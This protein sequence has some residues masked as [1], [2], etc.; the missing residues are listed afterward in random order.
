MVEKR[1]L[2]LRAEGRDTSEDQ[3][4]YEIPGTA[5]LSCHYMKTD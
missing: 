4:S 2:K 3:E 5:C 1:C